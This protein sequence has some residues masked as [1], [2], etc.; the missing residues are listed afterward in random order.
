MKI[1]PFRIGNSYRTVDGGSVTIVGYK[2]QPY[3]YSTVFCSEGIHRY[4][5]RDY[6]RVTG[7]P[8]NFSHPKNII[9]LYSEI[10]SQKV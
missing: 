6:G 7:S 5:D 1:E 10:E 8:F 4:C 2:H 9:P 3:G